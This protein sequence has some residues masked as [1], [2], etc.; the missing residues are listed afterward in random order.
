MTTF[1]SS[2]TYTLLKTELDSATIMLKH[3]HTS[4]LSQ[5]FKTILSGC[6]LSCSSGH[7]TFKVYS[8][9]SLAMIPCFWIKSQTFADAVLYPGSINREGLGEAVF[10]RF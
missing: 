5:V 8:M 4:A 9:K 2:V 7:Y 10:M 1:S 3:F 6:L